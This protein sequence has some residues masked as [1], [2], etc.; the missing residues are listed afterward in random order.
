MKHVSQVNIASYRG[1]S[2]IEIGGLSDV[3]VFLGPSNSG[4]TSALEAI[5]LA[6][7]ANTLCDALRR[8]IRSRGGVGAPSVLSLFPKLDTSRRIDVT[9][10]MNG[11]DHTRLAASLFVTQDDRHLL[12]I[13]FEDKRGS[14]VELVVKFDPS[15]ADF[16]DITSDTDPDDEKSV[17]EMD[18]AAFVSP[19]ELTDIEVFDE[20]YSDAYLSETLPSLL[21]ALRSVYPL[22][23]DIRPVKV[24]ADRWMSYVQLSDGVYPM[25]AMGDGFK[26]AMVLLSHALSPGL[27]LFDTP[28]A[29]QHVGGAEVLSKSI[30]EAAGGLG[31]QVMIATQ[32]LEF[33][34]ILLKDC[35]ECEVNMSV[36]RFE[37]TDKGIVANRPLS[38]QRA[39]DAR[40][41]IGLDL[42]R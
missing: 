28:E 32:S 2:D 26:A 41:L 5:Y 3:N 16:T 39:W 10:D 21:D 40:D 7:S 29:F 33:L 37:H 4:K 13:G 34:D 27:L 18:K 36:T 12:A 23:K 19:T 8:I 22:L 35:E 1:L 17:E 14:S 20:R 25:F 38:G 42:R 9:L 11:A 31:S 24:D 15:R 6:S 30:A